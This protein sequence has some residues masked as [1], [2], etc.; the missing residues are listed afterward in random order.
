MSN[1]AAKVRL[2]RVIFKLHIQGSC[3]ALGSVVN[4]DPH[5]SALILA[6]WIRIQEGKNDT[7][8]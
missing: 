7:Q 4:P 6:S 5:E 3:I 2:G 8:K 1:I